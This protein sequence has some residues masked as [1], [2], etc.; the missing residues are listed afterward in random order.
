MNM[1]RLVMLALIV[2]MLLLSFAWQGSTPGVAA[3]PAGFK[4]IG[5]MPSWVGSVSEVQFNKLTHVN[6]A[7]V[8]PNGNGSL[9][10]LENPSKLSQL[11][12]AG[13]ANGVKV[14]ISIG[15]WNDGNDSGFESLAA[16][17]SSRTTFVNNVVNLVNTYNLDG[18]DIDWEYPDP[19]S[20]ADNYALLM[21]QLSSAMHSRGKLLT[22]AVVAEGYTGGGVKNEVFNYVDF[23]NIMSYDGGSP[24]A[25]Y[26]YAV[27]NLDYWQGRGL[28]ASK[29]VLGVPFYARPGG[30]SYKQAVAAD[31]QNAYRDCA[32]VN[33]SYGCYNGIP[34]I[35]AKTKLSMQRGTG[36]M[37]WELSQDT[38]DSTS[39]VSAI[40]QTANDGGPTLTPTPTNPPGSNVYQAEAASYG[41]GVTI[42]S[43]NTGFLGTGYANFPLSGGYVQFNNA[44]GG[45]GGN[46]TLRIRYALG[47]TTSRTGLLIVN[48]ASQNITFNPTGA[49]TTWVT[50][51][52]TVPLNGGTTNT[53][54]FES[55][56]QDLANIDQIQVSPSGGPTFTPTATATKTST[57]TAT[58]TA[59][60]P[61]G[62]NVYQA[63]AASLGGGVTVDSNHAGFSGTGFVNFPLSGGY[64]QFN[65]V[66]GGTGGNATLRIRYALGATTSRTGLLI[67]NGASQ[68]VTFN[69]TGAWATWVT[70]DVVVSLNNG[71]TN[72]LRFESNGQ[73]LGNLDQIEI[74]LSGGPTN[75]PTP[76]R[77]PT[78]T[79]P[80]TTNLALNRP[81]T[82]SSVESGTTFT[83][84]LAVDGSTG[85]RW[86]SNYSDPQWL[87]VDLGAVYSINRVVLNWEAA[88]G[89]AYQIQVSND[90]STWM[91]IYST[92]T[93]NGGIDDLAGLSGSGR[94]IRVYGT[95]RATQWGYSLWEFEVYGN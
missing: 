39:L 77:T 71:T 23:L 53:L 93:G 78:A 79:T 92:T 72:T 15:G 80:T 76:T 70:S 69:P 91:T 88:Y 1:K 34:T 95:T 17:S 50:Q 63:E 86:S 35:Q 32:T 18:A 31:P 12:S 6:Y 87:Q 68:N 82:A 33:G 45:T 81:A 25:S 42:D 83:A 8:V 58:S 28:P 36:I 38:S 62:G 57:P 67:V 7:F 66:N 64:V 75:T 56:G 73:D 2:A 30:F 44:N 13:H 54:R 61:P 48:G 41:G 43:N 84:N 60:Q 51:D 16:N 14:L 55:N 27:S 20:S 90:A 46:A 94:Y 22:A 3:A 40:Y 89:T 52:V 85:T 47:A 11:V 29:T 10:A 49:W 26:A 9:G 65:G 37:F 21:N 24:H 59:T 19:G 4:I 74:I 5:Y